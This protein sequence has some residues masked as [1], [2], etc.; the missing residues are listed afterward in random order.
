[1]AERLRSMLQPAKCFGQA[2]YLSCRQADCQIVQLVE[3]GGA[4]VISV[5]KCFRLVQ[6]GRSLR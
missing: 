3:T 4:L 2:I 6:E 5:G 1:M